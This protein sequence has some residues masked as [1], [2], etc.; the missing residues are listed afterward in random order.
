VRQRFHSAA[1]S[2]SSAA[3]GP[4]VVGGRFRARPD[5]LQQ[6]PTQRGDAGGVD[7]HGRALEADPRVRR[8]RWQ[9]RRQ[10]ARQH[11]DHREVALDPCHLDVVPPAHLDARGREGRERALHRAVLAERR[12]DA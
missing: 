4:A 12:Q 5:P 1:R 7:Q 2:D 6:S 3:V 11:L 8:D 9:R 10:H